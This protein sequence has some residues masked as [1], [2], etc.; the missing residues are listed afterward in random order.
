MVQK[1]TLSV[2][3]LVLALL[4]VA[5][6]W[7]LARLMSGGPSLTREDL[8]V[9]SEAVMQRVDVQTEAL[10]RHVDAR[11]ERIERKLDILLNIATNVPPDLRR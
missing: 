7:L 4:F 2:V 11:A 6:G 9:A 1:L 8:A 3:V 10:G 5:L